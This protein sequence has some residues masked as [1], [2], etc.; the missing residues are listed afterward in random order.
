MELN[1]VGDQ[2]GKYLPPLADELRRHYPEGRYTGPIFA[3]ETQGDFLLFTQP[4]D[5][6]TAMFSHA[7]AF[8]VPYWKRCLEVK[9]GD[10]RWKATLREWKVNL[11]VAEPMFNSGLTNLLRTDP[12][13]QIILDEEGNTKIRDERGRKVIALRK[14][15]LL[16]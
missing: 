4:A 9:A 3:T 8:P 6:P 11:I 7:H 1:A 16:P 2:R 5:R 15:P 13:W 14:E 10:P 12:E